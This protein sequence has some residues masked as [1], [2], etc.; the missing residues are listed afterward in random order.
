MSNNNNMQ[1]TI[2]A[3]EAAKV[4]LVQWQAHGLHNAGHAPEAKA[5]AP[6]MG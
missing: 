3:L 2:D 1:G 6:R 5:K 4:S